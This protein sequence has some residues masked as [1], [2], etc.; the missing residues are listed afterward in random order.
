MKEVN[1]QKIEGQNNH[2]IIGSNNQINIRYGLSKEEICVLIKSLGVLNKDEVAEIIQN[3]L[4]KMDFSKIIKPDAR[5]FVPMVTQ[6][7]YSFNEDLIKQT[8][9]KMLESSLNIDKRNLIHPAFVQIISQLNS[10]EI[11]ILNKLE[12]SSLDLY[13]LVSMSVVFENKKGSM[14]ASKYFSDIG[15]GVCEYPENICSYLE[16]LERLKIIEIPETKH[17]SSDELYEN[18]INHNALKQLREIIQKKYSNIVDFEYK[19]T[20]FRLTTFGVNF[21]SC[22]KI[23]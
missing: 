15:Y 14:V 11:K 4:D 9:K 5:I 2:Q 8:Y 16:N 1:D 20:F 18:L 19:K 17:I 21:L 23:D 7:S 22:C 3:T 6:L 12:L 13:P 10:E